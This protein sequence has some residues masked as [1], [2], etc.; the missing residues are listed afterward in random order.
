MPYRPPRNRRLGHRR[1][2]RQRFDRL[3]EEALAEIPE[4][5]RPYL[6][7]VA[8]VVED[9]PDEQDLAAMGIPPDD[10]IFG[11]HRGPPVGYS[12]GMTAPSIIA[13]YRGPIEEACETDAEIR[14]EVRTTVLHEVGHF[15]GMSEEDLARLGLA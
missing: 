14:R 6:E 15:F 1:D 11:L 4:R 3:V 5:F 2:A 13:I 10:T 12:D 7:R 8:I 9:W